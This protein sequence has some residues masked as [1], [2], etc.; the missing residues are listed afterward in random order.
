MQ[1]FR[2][3]IAAVSCLIVAG[4][5]FALSYVAL[6]D[7]AASIGAVP[8]HLAWLVPIV[9]D[10][11]IMCGS[12]VIWSASKE[13]GKRPVFPFLFVG[14][15]VSI[16]VVVNAS[17]A[18]DVLLAKVI[19]ALPPLILLGTL[20]LVASQGRKLAATSNDGASVASSV[21]VPA[22]PSVASGAPSAPAS[23]PRRSE[24]L[25]VRENTAKAAPPRP[26]AGEELDPE[27]IDDIE[28]ALAP[29]RPAATRS[30]RTTTSAS[31]KRA[32]RVQAA[33]A[34]DLA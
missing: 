2:R 3:W 21:A 25:P 27:L 28:E 16:S 20:E 33:Q 8:A 15:M 22:T 5:S 7:V 18:A 30:T 17:H 9:I 10:G 31:A 26:E 19:A 12:A 32:P 13:D 29:V 34:D 14:S 4:A 6:R 1:Q 11:G 24:Q 23:S